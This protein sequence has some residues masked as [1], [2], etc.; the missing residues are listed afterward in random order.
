M[1]QGR[2]PWPLKGHH[3]VSQFSRGLSGLSLLTTTDHS[4]LDA[5]VIFDI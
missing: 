2:E 4:G 3:Q 5:P 1:V